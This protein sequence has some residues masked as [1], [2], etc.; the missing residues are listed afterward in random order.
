ML[1]VVKIFFG[2]KDTQPW[3]VLVCLLLAGLAS[4]L[5]LAS[6]LPLVGIFVEG[7]GT[8]YST[9]TNYIRSALDA[10]GL[11][12]DI[13]TLLTIIFVAISIKSLLNL[14]AMSYV[15]NAL[16]TVATSLRT[17]LIKQ[18][19]NVRWSYLTAKPLGEIA[20]AVS[21][22]TTRSGQAYMASA[23]FLA[24][25][26]E[27]AIYVVIA[28]FVSWKLSLIGVGVG[29]LIALTLHVFVGMARRAGARQQRRTQE[30]VT[31]LTDA[32]NNV[33]PLKAMARQAGFARLFENRIRKIKKAL[34]AQYVTQEAR[35]SLEEVL[36]TAC[37]VGGFYL[38]V[39]AWSYSIS[40]VLVTGLILHQSVGNIGRIQR[41]YQKAVILESPYI[42]VRKLIADAQAACEE[43]GKDRLPTLE[44]GCRLEEIDFSYGAK[45]VL[46]RVSIDVPVGQTTVLIGP[47]GV[48]KTTIADL[49]IGLHSP[50]SG[51]ILIDGVPLEELNLQAWRRMIGYVP[52]ELILFHDSIA[53][54]ISLGDPGIGGEEVEAAL[55]AAGALRFVGELPDGAMT[56]VGEKGRKLSGGQRQ[57]IAL[58]RALA[59]KPKLLILD[60]ASSALDPETEQDLCRRI[61]ALSSDMAILAITH[62][63]PF[64]EIADRL[65]KVHD[66]GVSPLRAGEEALESAPF[67]LVK[68]G[69]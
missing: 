37:F 24:K 42:A 31:Y 48:G 14:L 62:R 57:R 34:R 30:L 66:G 50:D 25:V 49:L 47:S 54:N 43:S 33:K 3:T 5:G 8:S 4:G 44:E 35:K 16:A 2:A 53:A 60:E 56:Q 23:N 13:P 69:E 7:E 6:L 52:Q 40:E 9:L 36:I 41:Y 68:A 29:G 22:D 19:L 20:N 18:L 28:F 11:S 38:V 17:Q 1:G 39:V 32:L 58:A 12:P 63:Q 65:Y 26:I 10:V 67:G 61:Q 59:A 55:E 15:G 45:R 51:R 21:V 46:S 64:L 27:T